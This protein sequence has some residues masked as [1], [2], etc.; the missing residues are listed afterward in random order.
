MNAFALEA[1]KCR[2]RKI[3][4]MPLLILGFQLLWILWT[5]GR[6][7]GEDL[8]DGWAFVIVGTQMLN[9]LTMPVLASVTASRVWDMEH[10]G[11]TLKLLKTLTPSSGIFH[12][13]LLYGYL[14]MFL[15]GF[16]QT[17]VIAAAGKLQGFY[18]PV[19]GGQLAYAFWVCSGVNLVIY[20][21]YQIL[22]MVYANQLI[23]LTAGLLGAFI[24]FLS[25]L[26]PKSLGLLIPWGYYS[27]LS[28]VAVSYDV[29]AVT[30]HYT[31]IPI[32]WA[33]W[34]PAVILLVIL[35]PAGRIL[36]RKK[37]V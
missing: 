6:M 7:D 8:R 15:C 24:G 19:P 22:S 4:V 34:I 23:P 1:R 33:D 5:T 16:L 10:K 17:L 26:F 30:A 35:Y 11:Q 2:R 31:F 13:K 21:I 20:L 36:L 28:S 32:P 27:R 25:N 12:G 9:C 29:E 3:W 37:E 14:W 18:G